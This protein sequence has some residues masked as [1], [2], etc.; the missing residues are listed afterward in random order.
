M[1]IELNWGDVITRTRDGNLTPPRRVEKTQAE[2]RDL[3]TEDQFSITRLKGTEPAHSSGM[4]SLFEPGI[5][6]CV[7]CKTPLFDSATKYESGTGWPSFSLPIKGNVVSY[8]SDSSHGMSRIEATCSICDAHLGHVFPDG[9]EPSGL[10][11]CMNALSLEKQ[12]NSK[13]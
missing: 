9:P 7:C 8:V 10:R 13:A 11:F 6:G 1:G 5:Y 12:T 4:C 3:L 2:W